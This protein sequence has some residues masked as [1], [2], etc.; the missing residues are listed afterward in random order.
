M[1]PFLWDSWEAPIDVLDAS[2]AS[3]IH[4]RDVQDLSGIPCADRIRLSFA[5]EVAP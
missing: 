2:K 1:I 5:Q 4:F 3:I